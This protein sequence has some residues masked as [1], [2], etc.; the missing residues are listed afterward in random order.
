TN[1][2]DLSK[3]FS[4]TIDL[5]ELQTIIVHKAAD[6]G[7]AE[8]ASLWSFEP[9][10]SEVLLVASAVNENYAVENAPD[11]VGSSIVGDLLADGRA[12]LRN[13]IPPRDPV[14]TENEGYTIRSVLAFPLIEEERPVGALVM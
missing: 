7:V 12:L 14:A 2:Y 1:L 8:V 11:G 4:S 13:S 5:S 6:F 9:G 10:T 3:A